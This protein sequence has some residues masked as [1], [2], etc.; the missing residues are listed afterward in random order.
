MST[1]GAF[2]SKI[3][4]VAAAAGSAVGL[5][6]IWRFPYEAGQHGGGAFLLV[7]LIC[8]VLI[9]YPIMSGEIT[10]GRNTRSNPYRAYHKLGNRNWSLVGIWGIICGIMF[11]SV[12]NVVAGWAFGYFIEITFGSLLSIKDFDAHFDASIADVSDNII[13]SFA[14]MFIT[15]VIVSRGIQGGIEKASKILMP[16]LL[17]LLLGLI[18]YSLTLPNAMEG[19]K[20]YLVPDFSLIN[21]ETI[22]SALGQ[23]FFSLSLGMGALITYGSYISKKDNIVVS[24][25]LVTITDT[26]VAF[27]AGLMIFPLVF[28]IGQ[29]PAAGPG[30]VFVTLPVIFQQIG[31]IA[32]KIIGSGF[33]LLLCFAALT[34][35]ISL[36]EIPT[37]FLVD[38]KKWPRKR[39]AWIS[40]VIIFIIGLPS[41]L[42]QGAVESLTHF[43]YYEGQSK[44]VFDFVFDVF[45][46]IGL[47][48]GGLLMVIF[49]ARKWGMKKFDEELSEGNSNYS[50]SFMSTFLH[51]TIKWIAPVFLAIIFVV[52]V[53][54]KF[55]GIHI[56]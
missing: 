6:N 3:G 5:G 13:Y 35:T 46:D 54:Q 25:G 23:A 33:F 11:L 42:S 51:I 48:L 17:L 53:L 45:S 32:G 29:S 20:Y 27:L 31:P 4:F 49:I 19:I 26:L 24:A 56:F 2:S 18:F 50:G 37:T 43:L 55:F 15:A 16:L 39:I 38:E 52:T 47:P 40:A 22:Y 8:I 36:L 12:Y 1:R 34:S 21:I 7:Y 28:S 44:S 41:M 30:L 9:G 10:L 14:F